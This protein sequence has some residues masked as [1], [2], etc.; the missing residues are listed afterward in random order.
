[1]YTDDDGCWHCLLVTAEGY[2]YGVL[3]ESGGYSYARYAAII[4]L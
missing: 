3:I 1:M 2:S 4:T